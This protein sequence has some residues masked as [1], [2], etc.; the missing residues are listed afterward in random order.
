MPVNSPARRIRPGARDGDTP[1]ARA[2][3]RWKVSLS[4][5]PASRE[6]DQ[7]FSVQPYGVVLAIETG[8][9]AVASVS[10]ART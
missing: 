5:A 7:Y 3:R 6:R 2:F 1:H 8:L 4:P 10:A 9:P